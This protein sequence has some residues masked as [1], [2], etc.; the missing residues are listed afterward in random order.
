MNKKSRSKQES[1]KQKLKKHTQF[2]M[3]VLFFSIFLLFSTLILR[4][5]YLQIVKG[6]DYKREIERTEE[7]SVNTSVPRGRIYD[8]NG[9]ILVGNEPKNAITYTKQQRTTTEDMLKTAQK[10]AELIDKDPSAVTVRDKKDFWILNHK[11]EAYDKVSDAEKKKINGSETKSKTE[12]Q[13]ELDNL[14]RDRITDEEINSFTPEELEVLAIYREMASGYNYSPQIIKSGDVTEEEYALVSERLGDMPGVNTTTDWERVRNSPLAVLGTTTTPKQGIPQDKLD[15]YLS[16]GYSRNDRVGKSYIEQQYESVLQGQKTVAKN[17]TDRT[18]TVID[19]VAVQEGRPGKDLVLTIDSELQTE[20]ERIVSEKLLALKRNY[21]SQILDRAFYVMLNPN[22]GEVLAMVGKQIVKNKDGQYEVVDISFGTYGMAYEVGSTVKMATVLT[23]YQYGAASMGEVKIDEPLWIGGLKKSSLFNPRD[24]NRIPINDMMALTRSSN[25]YMFK[26]AIA[27]G[28]GVYERR[29]GLSLAPDTIDKF[30][31]SFASFGLGA[32][33]GIDLPSEFSGQKGINPK[34]GNVLDYAI[35]QYDTY[36]A[37]QLAQYVSTVANGGYRIAPHVVKEIRE[38]SVD[39]KTLGQLSEEVRPTILNRIANS[40]T[41]IDRI[42]Q[43]MYS[44]YYNQR[45]TAY[46][47]FHDTKY[48]AAGKTGTAQKKYY[49]DPESPFYTKDTV[50]VSHVGFAPFEEPEMAYA[51]LVP[52]VT[53]VPSKVP[54]PNNEIARHMADFYFELK[55]KRAAEGISGP[56]VDYTLKEP[57]NGEAI[58]E[59][60]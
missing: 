41:E 36:T 55:E 59:G 32:R 60:E 43:A 10:L 17:V 38:P 46:K 39:G 9:Q 25:V 29:A 30:R 14:V 52:N 4:L 13:R 33:T 50:T 7:I 16:R 47:D 58:R 26:I 19:T 12:R 18:G 21:G 15:Y 42:Q 44:V 37:M 49:D 35:G 40:N 23:G 24:Y 57:E 54:H 1:P 48:K 20:A 2:R 28:G 51:V 53:T 27:L 11:E 3:N 8:R 6:D 45:G 56:D 22:N 31:G 5:G 34:P